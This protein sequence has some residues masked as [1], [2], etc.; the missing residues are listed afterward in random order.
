VWWRKKKWEYGERA[1]I[2]LGRD[3]DVKE[4]LGV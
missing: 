1:E 4:D 3:G 2:V